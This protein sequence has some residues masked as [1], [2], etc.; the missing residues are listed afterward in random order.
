MY[1][2][3]DGALHPWLVMMVWPVFEIR[4]SL[5]P[6]GMEGVSVKLHTGQMPVKSCD[7]QLILQILGWNLDFLVPIM[8]RPLISENLWIRS[9]IFFIKR[10]SVG[11]MQVP[12]VHILEGL[13][14]QLGGFSHEFIFLHFEDSEWSTGRSCLEGSSSVEVFKMSLDVALS[15][16][17]LSALLLEGDWVTWPSEVPFNL[18]YAIISVFL[19]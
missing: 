11:F 8:H 3:C 15:N 14:G 9:K 12:V 2:S 5:L 13:R 16:T 7:E 19:L 6:H 18:N 1:L 4:W 17:T 10:F